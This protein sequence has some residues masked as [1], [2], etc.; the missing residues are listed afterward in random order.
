MARLL[1]GAPL[2]RELTSELSLRA[3]ALRAEHGITPTLA[4]IRLGE[5]PDDLA[6]ERGIAKRAAQAGVSVE[7]QA[8]AADATMDEVRAAVERVNGCASIHG[9]VVLR[10]L[11]PAIDEEAVAAALDPAK[12]LDGMTPG[13]LY[14]V[15]AGR[16]VGFAPCT[17]EAVVELIERSGYELAGARVCV[18]GRSLVIGRP[19]ALMLQ[20]RDATV[21]LC[22]SRTRDLSRACREAEIL[23]VATGH[24]AT[25][26][27]SMV[28]P[29]QVVIDVGMNADP[30]TGSLV[31]DVAFDE[32]EPVVEA[33][34]PVPGGVGP[35]TSAVLM[36]H[37]VEAAERG[38]AR[39]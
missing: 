17:A 7:H 38:L 25:V 14:G 15:F 1:K 31:G 29:G 2:A 27:S 26:R 23:I 19:V 9:C 16:A 22:H 10:P 30:E 39:R 13:A 21:T 8:L 4:V 3:Q 32:V 6:Y 11:P 18:V 28:S 33:I 24:P 12:D 36:K 34:T 37:V 20:A 35:L 5:R